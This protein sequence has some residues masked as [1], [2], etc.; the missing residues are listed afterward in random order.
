MSGNMIRTRPWWKLTRE[1]NQG[2]QLGPEEIR[3]GETQPNPPQ[4][5]DRVGF[6]G[7]DDLP[8]ELLS[9]EIEG[10]NGHRIG[11][12]SGGDFAIG[13]EM[14]LLGRQVR[15]HLHVEELGTV[16]S[17][18]GGV[19]LLCEFDLV[20]QVDIREDGDF[21][22]VAGHRRHRTHGEEL[23]LLLL[24]LGLPVPILGNDRRFRIEDD[25]AFEGVKGDQPRFPRRLAET[26]SADDDGNPERPGD[27]R[28]VGGR[29]AGFERESED[30]VHGKLDSL[31][32]RQVI[33]DEDRR[34]IEMV[35]LP[36]IQTVQG[37]EN[38]S[39]PRRE[40][41]AFGRRDRRAAALRIGKPTHRRLDRW[42][43]PH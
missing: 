5:E 13:L 7:T 28:G 1:S 33:R 23:G 17:D 3:L 38:L 37:V 29:A 6:G 36:E 12:D 9:A 27:D 26:L 40:H 18:T 31:G 35:E 24:V 11:T 2:P 30:L 41:R 25:L 14:V 42:P 21:V 15:A 39:S 4:T 32:R 19:P 10:P 22:T 43:T 8:R 34:A 16:E 20:R